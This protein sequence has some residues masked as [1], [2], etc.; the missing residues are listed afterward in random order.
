MG[1][2]HWKKHVYV[3]MGKFQENWKRNEQHHE[4]L[5]GKTSC[6][7]KACSKSKCHL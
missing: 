7:E 1:Q 4:K 6:K 3:S 2:L 5:N